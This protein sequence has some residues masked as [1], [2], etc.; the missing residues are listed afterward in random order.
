MSYVMSFLVME[1]R[2]ETAFPVFNV[3][4]GF[5]QDWRTETQQK[6]RQEA[7]LSLAVVIG[8]RSCPSL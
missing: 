4:C 8:Q 6:S 2:N 3:T 5:P 1:F 7:A